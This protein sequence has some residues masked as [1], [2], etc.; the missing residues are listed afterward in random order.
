MKIQLIDKSENYVRVLF[1]KYTMFLIPHFRYNKTWSIQDSKKAI[2]I[3]WLCI[4]IDFV[5][6]SKSVQ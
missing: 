4:E 1:N 3:Y 2:S 5:Y 6:K